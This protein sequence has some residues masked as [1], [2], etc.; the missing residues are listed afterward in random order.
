MA[1][2]ITGGSTQ[3]TANLIT[4]SNEQHRAV[5]ALEASKPHYDSTDYNTSGVKQDIATVHAS[6]PTTLATAVDVLNTAKAKYN[7][8]LGYH[9]SGS[10]LKIY[11]HKVVDATNTISTADMSAGSTHEATILASLKTLIDELRTDYEAH[12]AN[13]G[14]VWHADA[15]ATPTPDTAN[16]LGGQP[17]ITSLA[18]AA[19]EL[20][21]LKAVYNAHRTSASHLVPDATNVVTSPNC[22]ST[23]VDS[24]VALA[25]EL[26]T[27]FGAHLG[28][29]G[30]HAVNDSV[31]TIAGAAV[32]LPAGLFD[33]ANELRTDYE[34]HR[35]STTYHES[36]DATNTISAAAAT[37]VATLIAL[38][39]ELRTDIDSHMDNAP[40]SAALRAA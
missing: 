25:N 29:A 6:A 35:A 33:L 20:N 38:A 28:Q 2:Q 1:Y 17:T 31:N 22:S 18:E 3:P 27:D 4:A 5:V 40:I 24:M 8:H 10:G 37:T 19:T 12:R 7:A 26:R 11:A 23:D 34:A 13:S 32:S 9:N 14:G 36:A 15:I 16:I 39:A 21:L 30:V